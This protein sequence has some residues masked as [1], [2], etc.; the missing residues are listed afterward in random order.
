MSW[1]FIVC[2]V[3]MMRSSLVS[4]VVGRP[5]SRKWMDCVMGALLLVEFASPEAGDDLSEGL[6]AL[7]TRMSELGYRDGDFPE[8][9]RASREVISLPV[10]P[11]LKRE[12]QE[13]V[14]QAIVDYYA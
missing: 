11:E 5:F 3:E 2:L 9:E 6:R 7:E 13:R 8:S 4:R 12:H 1:S 14:A 10:F